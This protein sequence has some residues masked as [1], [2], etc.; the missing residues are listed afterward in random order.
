MNQFFQ[1]LSRGTFAF[2]AIGAGIIFI[3]ATDPPH[4]LCDSQVDSFKANQTNFLYVNPKNKSEKTPRHEKLLNQCKISNNPGGCYQ[5]FFEMR[6][7]F[8]AL[9]AVPE[10]CNKEVASLREV[11]SSVEEA[12]ELM[13]QIAWGEKPPETY[14]EKFNW[15][16]PAAIS[17]FC[18]LKFVMTDSYGKS[19]WDRFQEKVMMASPGAKDISRTQMWEKSIFSVNCTQYP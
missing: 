8:Q 4:T 14:Y 6:R 3:I 16:D 11:K 5:Y 15:L 9:K 10:E 1:T 13:A 2:I 12:I 18:R 17:L 7:L 19:T